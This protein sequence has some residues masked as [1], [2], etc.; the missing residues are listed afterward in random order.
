MF[1][2]INLILVL[3]E[4]VIGLTIFSFTILGP[5]GWILDNLENYKKKDAAES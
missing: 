5:S 3:K 1:T 2:K 4:T